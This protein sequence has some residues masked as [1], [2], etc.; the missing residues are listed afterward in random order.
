LGFYLAYLLMLGIFC[1]I[2]GGVAGILCGGGFHAGVRIGHVIAIVACPA[3]GLIL[4]N[5]K[6]AFSFQNVLLAM[7][8]GALAL[9]G[10][11]L[12]GLLPVSFLTTKPASPSP[13]T[14]EQEN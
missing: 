6:R 7:L 10:G 9:F 4:L 12:L 5:Q 8:A 13:S 2:A 1:A 3:I 14:P 11:G